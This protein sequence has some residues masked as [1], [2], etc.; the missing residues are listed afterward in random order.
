VSVHENKTVIDVTKEYERA[1]QASQDWNC[2][3]QP[4]IEKLVRAAYMHGYVAGH[5]D[6]RAADSTGESR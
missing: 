3:E 1:T 5:R 4:N 6:G 2:G